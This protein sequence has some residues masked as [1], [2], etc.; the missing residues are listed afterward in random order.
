MARTIRN[1][2]RLIWTTDLSPVPPETPAT[3]E[4]NVLLLAYVAPQS[5]D[6][7]STLNLR[8]NSVNAVVTNPTVDATA[9]IS[10]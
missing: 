3:H 7:S 6:V 8:G 4:V 1:N 9:I 2:E 5:K 10:D